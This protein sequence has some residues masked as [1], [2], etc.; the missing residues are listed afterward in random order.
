MLHVG[1]LRKAVRLRADRLDEPAELRDLGLLQ[2]FFSDL[3]DP[4]DRKR[5]GIRQLAL[6]RARLAASDAAGDEHVEIPNAARRTIER[7][8]GET[9]RMG[10][11]YERD[12][13]TFWEGVSETEAPTS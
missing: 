1:W 12:A 7:W 5:I 3:G 6:H 4:R 9:L 11:P 2:L 13:V 10:L 8:R